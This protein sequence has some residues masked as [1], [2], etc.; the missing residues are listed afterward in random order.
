MGSLRFLGFLPSLKV[1]RLRGNRI[2]T[3]YCKPN[4]EDKVFKKGLF[5]MP[6]LELLDVSQN[7]LQFMYGL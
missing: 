6:S 1:L 4:P 5:G 2:E 3:L 7:L